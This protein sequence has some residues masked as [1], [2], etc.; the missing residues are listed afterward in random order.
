MKYMKF[1]LAG[2]ALSAITFASLLFNEN[3]NKL[4]HRANPLDPKATNYLGYQVFDKDGDGE[5]DF[6]VVFN[7]GSVTATSP[8]INI[9]T[10]GAA[11]KMMVSKSDAFAG[12]SWEKFEKVKAFTFAP[13]NGTKTVYVKYQYLGGLEGKKVYKGE[14]T[15]SV[16]PAVTPSVVINDGATFASN[17]NVTLTFTCVDGKRMMISTNADLAGASWESFA[18]TKSWNFVA[19][20]TTNKRWVFVRYEYSDYL[21]S[22]AVVSNWIWPFAMVSN[23]SLLLLTGGVVT[24]NLAIQLVFTSHNA[25]RMMVSSNEDFSSGSGWIVYAVNM[26]WVFPSGAGTN[27][28]FAQFANDWTTQSISTNIYVMSNRL[29]NSLG[30]SFNLLLEGTFKQ[31]QTSIATP[32]QTNVVSAFYVSI[33]ETRYSDWTNVTTWAGMNGYTF[34]GSQQKGSGDTGSEYQ[35][36]T[37]VQW[38][39]AIIWCNALSQKE[40]KTPAYYLNEAKTIVYKVGQSNITANMVNWRGNGYRLP[41]EAEWEYACRAGTTSTYFWGESN[42]PDSTTNFVWY[43]VNSSDGSKV[44]GTKLPNNW[45]IY[46][47]IGNVNEWCWDWSA[48]YTGGN[49]VNPLGASSGTLRVRRSSFW[50]GTACESAIRFEAGPSQDFNDFGFRIVLPAP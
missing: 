42:D 4:D 26:P 35:P 45:G 16:T 25:T 14:V 43:H 50:I 20:G 22:S 23:S 15:L 48:V 40:G 36:V 19:D 3:R 30:M 5:P 8:T 31:G 46:D 44:C 39:D 18:A 38:Y 17:T 7:D 11:L 28:L 24:T 41:T 47:I 1:I 37:K 12:A 6:T 10:A 33:Y 21:V 29:S 13:P 27:M 34:N 32:V 2:F 49:K 9:T